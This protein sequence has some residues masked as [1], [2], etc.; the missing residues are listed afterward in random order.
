MHDVDVVLDLV[1]DM[2]DA[3]QQ[4]SWGVLKPGGILVSLVQFPSPK[5]AAEHGV[6][7]GFATAVGIDGQFLSQIAAMIDAGKVL[8]VVSHT[9]PLSDI[10]GAHAHSESRHLRGK[11]VVKVDD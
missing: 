3:T 4:R 8:P 7:S 9:Y 2:G 6:R 1:G 10:Q 11:I 5:T